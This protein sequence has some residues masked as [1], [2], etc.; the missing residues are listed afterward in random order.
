MSECVEWQ[1]YRTPKGYGQLTYKGV[2]WRAHR[3]IYVMAY[4]P[5]P[6]GLHVLHS[7]DNPGCVNP[8]HLHL[9]THQENMAEAVERNRFN[10]CVGEDNP[11]AKITAAEVEEIRVDTRRQR[12]I[13]ADYGVS[14]ATVSNIKNAKVWCA[15]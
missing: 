13:A 10:P 15:V 1:K 14:Q 2:R 9:G 8:D 3:F 7:C 11:N 6:D 12:D 4:G 5:I